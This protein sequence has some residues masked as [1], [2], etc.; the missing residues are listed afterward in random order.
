MICSSSLAWFRM[1][2]YHKSEENPPIQDSGLCVTTA[3]LQRLLLNRRP[4]V[5]G[6]TTNLCRSKLQTMVKE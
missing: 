3:L 1:C 6:L 4:M 5:C 2:T